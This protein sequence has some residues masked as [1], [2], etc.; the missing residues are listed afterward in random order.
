[1]SLKQLTNVI[2]A[3]TPGWAATYDSLRDRFD[4]VPDVFA[5]VLLSN[6]GIAQCG[7]GLSLAEVQTVAA[8]CSGLASLGKGL[9]L[10]VEGGAVTH[11]NVTL[12]HAHVVVTACGEGSN[13]VAYIKPNGAIGVS[14]R[15][16][17]R[18]ARAF[19]PQLSTGH[20]PDAQA[21]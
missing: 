10:P 21:Q 6:D 16:T 13:L 18:V 3:E 8:A 12:E 20:R 1:M 4:D 19:G 5:L 2:T 15:E 17:V 7:Y 11:T 14:I 9:S